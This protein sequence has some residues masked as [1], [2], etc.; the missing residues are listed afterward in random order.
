MD[1][2]AIQYTIVL[3]LPPLLPLLLLLLLLLSTT[4]L[5]LPQAYNFKLAGVLSQKAITCI[6]RIVRIPVWQEV[7]APLRHV[8][9]TVTDS[10]LCYYFFTHVTPI[11]ESAPTVNKHAAFMK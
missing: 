4:R 8:V 1:A 11:I 5:L 2:A 3:L 6:V 9:G 7:K 10:I